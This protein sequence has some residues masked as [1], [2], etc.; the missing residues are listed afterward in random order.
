MSDATRCVRL[1][2]RAGGL[3]C[4]V[5][6]TALLVTTLPVVATADHHEMPENEMP[7]MSDEEKAMMAAWEKA[8]TPGEEHEW[9]AS[10]AGEYDATVKAWMDPAGE[11]MVSQAT[12][13]SKMIMGGRVLMEKVEGTMMGEPFEGMGMTGFDNVTGKYW[14][15]WIDNMG[16]GVGTSWGERDGENLVMEM[17]YPDPMTGDMKTS[18]MTLSHQDDGGMVMEAHEMHGDEE[19]RT[20]EITYVKK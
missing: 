12:A 16:T 6:A 15:T 9:L 18:R 4:L 7:E 2:R 8:M 14:G 5:L 1:I 19:V 20:M 10:Q 11:P 3:F 13:T 17:E